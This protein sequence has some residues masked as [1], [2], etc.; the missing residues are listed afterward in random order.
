MADPDQSTAPSETPHGSADGAA[1]ADGL[2]RTALFETHLHLGARMVPFAG[3]SMPLQYPQGPL[4][5]HRHCRR[6]AGLFDVS[7]M[8]I[9]HLRGEGTAQALEGLIPAAVTTL[10]PGRQRYS[11]LTNDHGGIVDDLVVARLADRLSVVVNAARR[12]VDLAHLRAGLGPAVVVELRS[13]LALLALQGPAAQMVLQRHDR[14]VG[15]LVFMDVASVQ[16]AGVPCTVSRSG[17]TGED[18]FELAV[19]T[20][21]AAD[22]FGMLLAEPEVGPAGLGARDSLRLE[23]G[24]CLYGH[25]LDETTTPV[26]AGLVWAVP[27]RRRREGGFPGA[28]TIGA[29]LRDGPGRL[30]VGLMADGRRQVRAGADLRDEDGRP[31]GTVT[32]GGFGPTVGAPV[33]MGYVPPEL[34]VPG[35]ALVAEVRGHEVRCTVT[36]LPFVPHR[37]TRGVAR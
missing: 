23:A 28:A 7:H 33:A 9:V 30:R 35:T 8:G 21:A 14:S 26:E 10:E 18:G 24:L 13:D 17:Y 20:A 3:Y 2:A 27:P 12:D 5:E 25:D 37:Y 16:L 29:Q 15:D 36:E 32:S 4:A 19:P 31:A 1:V 6:R 22:I 11:F 34:A